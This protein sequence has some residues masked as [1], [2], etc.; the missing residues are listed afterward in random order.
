MAYGVRGLSTRIVF[1]TLYDRYDYWYSSKRITAENELRLVREAVGRDP[2]T[3]LEIGVGSG[4]FASRSG[5]KF[6]IDPSLNMLKLAVDRGVEVV[7]GVGE[8]LP[9]RD[10]VFNTVVLIVTLCFVDD[11][12]LVLKESYRVL[13]PGGRLIVCIVPRDSRWGEHYLSLKSRGHPFYS[14][15]RFYT[16][17]E[18]LSMLTDV[19]FKTCSV[20]GVL[21]YG[22]LDEERVEEPRKYRGGEGFVCIVAG[23]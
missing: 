14:V 1:E 15:A 12:L 20:L 13:R 21:T 18:V 10:G 3:C 9:F 17:S 16:V 7:Q 8:S 5:C 23:R 19:G 6:G 11:P 2:G 4:W 22:P